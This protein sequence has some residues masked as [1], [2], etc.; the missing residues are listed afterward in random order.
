MRK[1]I[2]A[3]GEVMM[4]LQVPGYETLAQANTLK[5]TFP[6]TGVNVTAALSRFGFETF[7]VTTL[8]D[9]PLGDA[10]AAY[11]RKLGISTK[12]VRFSGQYLGMYFLENGFG[13][14]PGRVTYTNRLTSSFNQAPADAYDFEQIAEEID[15]VHICGV[16]LAMNDN[17]R[18]QMKRFAQAVKAKGGYVIFDSTFR[19]SLWG[20][21]G[22]AKA[23]PHY[24]QMLE[25]ADLVML[26]EKDA[27][28]TLGMETTRT[29]RKE[30]LMELIPQAA[31]QYN[32]QVAAG[33]HRTVNPDLTHTIQGYMYKD[34]QFVFSDKLTFPV[35][36]RIG[37]G[38]A[39]MTGILH[40]EL[41]GKTPQ[42]TV[43]FAA[44]A[45]MLAH[46]VEGDAPISTPAEI[47][48]AMTGGMQDVK[49]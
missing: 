1:R 26:N 16:T 44:A 32:I 48:Q 19:P 3:F 47:E 17:V 33:T 49:R 23:R 29:D 21:D 11:L 42:Q 5:Y 39:Y 22:H 30:Q 34:G 8:P 15:I 20:S 2:A 10:A 14:R 35:L 46:A 41:T 25:L 7:M 37:A 27:M 18:E 24:E 36:D 45:A 31:K 43:D 13:A 4:R 9:N 12:F 38:D 28:L 6:G 40:G